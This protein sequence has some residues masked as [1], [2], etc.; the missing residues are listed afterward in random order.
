MEVSPRGVT[1]VVAW[2][3]IYRIMVII[4]T[5]SYR[6][7]TT[8]SRKTLIKRLDAVVKPRHDTETLCKNSSHA[9]RSA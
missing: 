6:G 7:L 8:V 5:V 3:I 4:S 2:L 9:T 1:G